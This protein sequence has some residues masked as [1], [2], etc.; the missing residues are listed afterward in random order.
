MPPQKRSEDTPQDPHE[1]K[2]S[3]FPDE[4]MIRIGYSMTQRRYM[5]I[6]ALATKHGCSE[7]A[8]IGMLLAIGLDLLGRDGA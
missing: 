7:D 8:A 6:M 1:L 3:A 5:Q 2:V 4:K